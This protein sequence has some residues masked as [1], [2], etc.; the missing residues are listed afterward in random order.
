MA[1]NFPVPETCN[2]CDFLALGS[3]CKKRRKKGRKGEKG[4]E[5]RK[6]ICEDKKAKVIL[7]CTFVSFG[8]LVGRE[9]G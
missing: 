4:R 7:T 3:S 9:R 6:K 2:T 1:T 8:E 5:E